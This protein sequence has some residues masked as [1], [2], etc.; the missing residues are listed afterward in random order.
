MAASGLKNFKEVIENKAYRINANDRNIFEQGDLQSFFG[1]SEDDVIEFIMYDFSE[2]QLPQKDNGLVRYISL[3]NQNINDYFLLSEGTMMTRNSLPSEYFIDVERLIKEAGYA[4]GLFKTQV[5]LIN[6]RLGSYKLDD[7]VWISEISPSRTEVRLFPLE[8]S[9]NINDIKERFNIFYNNGDFRS[10]IIYNALKLVESINSS[11]IDDFVKNIYGQGWYEKLKV[12]YKISN[13]DSFTVSIHKKFVESAYYEFTNRISDIKDLNYGKPRK[14]SPRLQ[15]S[16]NTIIKRLSE[17][18]V[19]SI[20]F[21]LMQKDEQLNST[22]INSRLVSADDA[23]TILQSK[24]SDIQIETTLPELK[25]VTIEKPTQ[26]EKKLGFIKKLKGE[27]PITE[28]E[29]KI[30]FPIEREN[31]NTGEIITIERPVENE[32][33]R[34]PIIIETPTGGGGGGGGFTGGGYEDGR[35][36][37]G[38][39]LYVSEATQREN[40]Q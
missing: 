14:T 21:H 5:S 39:D 35:G 8:K 23:P 10:D 25:I 13:F 28:P 18:I 40:I 30:I 38:R 11:V 36:G 19:N 7:K 15:L 26:D 24:S 1:L 33:D 17:L 22:S 27:T 9:S 4:N 37:L 29:P 12:E 34:L 20:N 31:P 2:N 6:K 32:R 16:E 3:T